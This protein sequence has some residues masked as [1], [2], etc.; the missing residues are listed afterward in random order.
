LIPVR[1]AKRSHVFMHQIAGIMV[2]RAL[3]HVNWKPG[4][5]QEKLSPINTNP[6]F[7]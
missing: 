7:Q 4:P 3:I 5:T 6:V 1:E 2:P